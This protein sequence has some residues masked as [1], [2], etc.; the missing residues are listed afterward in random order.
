MTQ[1]FEQFLDA[2]AAQRSSNASHSQLKPPDYLTFWRLKT[3]LSYPVYL[4]NVVFVEAQ[5]ATR[6]K[7]S[8]R[9]YDEG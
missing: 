5:W 9:G 2:S 1:L 6:V 4:A 7:C 8:H 3:S